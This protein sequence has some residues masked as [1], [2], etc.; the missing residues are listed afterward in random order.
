MP[1]IAMMSSASMSR[2]AAPAG[3]TGLRKAKPGGSGNYDG[4]WRNGGEGDADWWVF[5]EAANDWYHVE[6][7]NTRIIGLDTYVW[8]GSA[9]VLLTEY[10]PDVPVGPMPW[11]FMLLL[12][13]GYGI[14]K[15]RQH[16]LNT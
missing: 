7:G 11:L 4:E 16:L 13:V 12:A 15:R 10:E 3:P 9:W 2:A 5:N 8:T 14:S 1:S 6:T